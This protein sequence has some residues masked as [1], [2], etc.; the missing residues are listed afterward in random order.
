ME[1]QLELELIDFAV[2]MKHQIIINGK[3]QNEWF[4]NWLDCQ[5]YC[6]TTAILN[7]FMVFKVA[8]KA[9]THTF[10]GMDNVRCIYFI[11]NSFAL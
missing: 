8:C 6:E 10:T 7:I 1:N 9:H 11:V 2:N 5:L 4:N 3:H